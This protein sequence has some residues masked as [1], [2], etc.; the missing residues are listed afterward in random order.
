VAVTDRL[1]RAATI[2]SVRRPLLPRCG[3]YRRAVSFLSVRSFSRP[4]SGHF[5]RAVEK[6][7]GRRRSV[8]VDDVYGRFLLQAVTISSVPPSFSACGHFFRGRR[9][10]YEG[11]GRFSDRAPLTRE[12]LIP[13]P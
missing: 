12:S 4:S 2:I 9:H 8:M 10:K 7:G 13:N 5:G 6:I 3:D 1:A 11:R